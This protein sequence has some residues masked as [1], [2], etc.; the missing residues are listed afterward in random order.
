[1]TCFPSFKRNVLRQIFFS[2]AREKFEENNWRFF[3]CPIFEKWSIKKNHCCT[4]KPGKIAKTFTKPLCLKT[5]V[6]I[7][8]Q[9]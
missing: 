1:M 6:A 4:K 8:Y 2:N 3:I 9:K 7:A 5:T